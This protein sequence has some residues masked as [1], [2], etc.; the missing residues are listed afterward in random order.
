MSTDE[1]AAL[2]MGRVAR[3]VLGTLAQ[4]HR[5]GK[6]LST[7]QIAAN[8]GVSTGAAHKTLHE[9][10]RAQLV[11]FIEDTPKDM[12]PRK[13]WWLRPGAVEVADA[14]PASSAGTDDGSAAA[15]G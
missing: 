3:R 14:F 13:L 15:T 10:A 12:A 5:A 11:Q 1:V 6:K 7:R 4:A 2:R 8:A 9:F